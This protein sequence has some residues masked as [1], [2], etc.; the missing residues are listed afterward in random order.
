M[1]NA[2]Q[3]LRRIG[4]QLVREKQQTVLEEQG[5]SAGTVLEKGKDKDLLSLLIRANMDKDLP[6]EQQLSDGQVLCQIP[7]FMVAGEC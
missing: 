1:F 6:A 4:L 2:K 5:S 3:T 7:T